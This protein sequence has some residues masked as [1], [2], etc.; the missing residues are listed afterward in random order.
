LLLLFLLGRLQ[1][2]ETEPVPYAV[3]E[4][5]L[6]RLLVEF[7]PPRPTSPAYP[8]RRLA[9]DTTPAG[10]PLYVMS[11]DVDGDVDDSPGALRRTNAAGA[12]APGFVEALQR[13]PAL[14]DA[15]VAHLLSA[16]FPERL[17][18]GILEATGVELG[19]ADLVAEVAMLGRR[20]AATFRRDVL[21]AYDHRCAI[22]GFTATLGGAMVGVE[23]AHVRWWAFD[24]PDDLTNGLALCAMHHLLFDVGALGVTE[25]RTVTVSRDFVGHSPGTLALVTD[26]VGRDLGRPQAGLDEVANVHLDW[27]RREV[28]RGPGRL[29]AS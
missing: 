29:A 5:D 21:R 15:V 2:G 1:R 10:S 7:G 9:N 11:A 25:E 22:C 27:H 13:D 3:A 17:H 12:L 8:F 23:A 24:G 19:L 28:F 6:Q 26:L 20:R 16:N 14:F 18:Q 4:A